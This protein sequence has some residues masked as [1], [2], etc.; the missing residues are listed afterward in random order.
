MKNIKRKCLLCNS[1]NNSLLFE[2]KGFD[3][4]A[5]KLKLK[6]RPKWYLCN[7]CGVFFSVQYNKI[8][9][10]YIDNTLYDMQF[11]INKIKE[12][13]NKLMA[14]PN[15]KSDN[16]FRVKRVKEYHEKILSEFALSSKRK[17]KIL[18]VGAGTGFFLAKFL[19]SKYTGYALE[20]NKIAAAHIKKELKIEV[21][22]EYIEN[23]EFEHKFDIITLNKVVEHIK[24]PV[25]FLKIVSGFLKENGIIYIELPDIISYEKY[26]ETSDAFGTGHYM[27]YGSQSLCYLLN[28]CGLEILMLD[29]IN[30]P[31]LK[32]TIYAFARIK[33]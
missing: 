5:E 17:N 12:R 28:K 14:L 8:S 23:V 30:E 20:V 13:Y 31:S 2:Y 11:D 29:R 7:N 10:V 21:I 3:I 24:H 27:V 33:K 6:S 9:K 26:G 18:D 16:F 4:Y 15:E 19:D 25:N 32:S 1:L 22:D